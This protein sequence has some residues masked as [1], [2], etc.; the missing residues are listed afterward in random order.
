LL[1]RFLVGNPLAQARDCI[2]AIVGLRKIFKQLD[3]GP[4]FFHRTER[5]NLRV[6]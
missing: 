1:W 4:D 5:P 3:F 2:V 6:N